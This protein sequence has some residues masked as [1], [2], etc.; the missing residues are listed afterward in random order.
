MRISA[1]LG[2]MVGDRIVS[3]E[4]VVEMKDGKTLKDFFKQADRQLGFAKEKVFQKASKQAPP[5][6][7][8]L[9]GDRLEYPAGKK[10]VLRDGDDIAILTPMMGG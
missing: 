1:R 4:G 5:P 8:L 10:T 6:T 9:N 7:I 2:A 3:A